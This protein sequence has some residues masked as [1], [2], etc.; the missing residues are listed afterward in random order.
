MLKLIKKEPNINYASLVKRKLMTGS[1][2]QPKATGKLELKWKK[3]VY[4]LT[5]EL[6]K[7]LI[8]LYISIQICGKNEEI[9][10]L[11]SFKD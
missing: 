2:N 4:L 6:I 8:Q 10:L 9:K 7:K 1:A 5:P 3:K 11:C